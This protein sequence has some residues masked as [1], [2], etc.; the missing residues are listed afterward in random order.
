V[1]EN[2]TD[3]EELYNHLDQQ[4]KKIAPPIS[5]CRELGAYIDAVKNCSPQR[6]KNCV[7]KKGGKLLLQFALPHQ[8]REEREKNIGRYREIVP[9]K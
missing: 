3:D 7:T 8:Q 5:R 6:F 2:F 1:S 9:Q 4:E